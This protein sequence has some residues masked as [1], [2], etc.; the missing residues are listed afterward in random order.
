M[1]KTDVFEPEIGKTYLY[2]VT[3]NSKTMTWQPCKFLGIDPMN[4]DR[5]LVQDLT[6]GN[7]IGTPKTREKWTSK[8]KVIESGLRRATLAWK[9]TELTKAAATIKAAQDRYNM[10][11]DMDD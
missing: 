9:K 11:L 3:F 7:Q 1:A 8:G 10:I 5:W 4:R 6:R 2:R